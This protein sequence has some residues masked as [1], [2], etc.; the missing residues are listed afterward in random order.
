M[1]R[2]G[3]STHSHRPQ[4][5]LCLLREKWTRKTS[6]KEGPEGL[7][8][9]RGVQDTELLTGFTFPLFSLQQKTVYSTLHTAFTRHH[10]L[11]E[12]WFQSW[13]LW[14]NTFLLEKL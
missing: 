11:S 2:T 4:L 3:D 12:V 5:S 9:F 14:M 10:L 1:T 7:C 8:P 13:K 6:G